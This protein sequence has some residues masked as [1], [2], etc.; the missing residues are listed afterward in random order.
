[1]A[2]VGMSYTNE[3][4]INMDITKGNEWTDHSMPEKKYKAFAG[5]VTK[6]DKTRHLIVAGGCCTD[7]SDDPTSTWIMDIDGNNEWRKGQ[8]SLNQFDGVSLQYEDS[9]LAVGGSTDENEASNKI[10]WFD[11]TT[12]TWMEMEHKLSAGRENAAAFL[13]PNNYAVC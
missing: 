12:E 5:L 11:S 1:M 13:I 6:A 10:W 3:V 2:M 4:W 8:S 7:D 9:V